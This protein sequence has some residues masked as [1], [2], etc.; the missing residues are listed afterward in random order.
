MKFILIMTLP[1]LLAAPA[2]G[3]QLSME[4]E[5]AGVVHCGDTWTTSGLTCSLDMI[6]ENQTCLFT[7]A[8]DGMTLVGELV[9]D[10]EPLAGVR[11][12]EI[13]AVFYDDPGDA[14]AY[15][16][17]WGIPYGVAYNQ[18]EAETETLIVD[19]DGIDAE[20]LVIGGFNIH[21][22]DITIH[23]GPV[24]QETTTFGMLKTMFR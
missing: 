17:N 6:H 21:I 4:F 14:A 20:Y 7:S 10:L 5:H 24:E 19:P 23:F 18:Q 16:T 2:I 12:I 11:R 9:I 8:N 3:D 22:S 15:V 1:A 13:E